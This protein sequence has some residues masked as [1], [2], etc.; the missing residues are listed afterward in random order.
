V[1]EDLHDRDSAQRLRFDVL[2]VVDRRRQAAL[3]AGDDPVRQLVGR[4]AVVVPD[5]GDD[6]NIDVGKDVR[7]RARDYERTHEK[8]ADREHDERV[9]AIECYPDDPHGRE[10]LIILSI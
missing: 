6:W 3:E 2:D 7:R 8:D 1:K 4:H 5:D 10:T 9:G